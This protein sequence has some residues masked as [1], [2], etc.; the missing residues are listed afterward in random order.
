V[1]LFQ[2]IFETLVQFFANL[3]KQVAIFLQFK[4]HYKTVVKSHWD[5]Y[6][7]TFLAV[8]TQKTSATISI[9]PS[10]FVRF[11]MNAV[12]S[13]VSVGFSKFPLGKLQGCICADPTVIAFRKLTY[14]KKNLYFVVL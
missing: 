2:K 6:Q 11:E 5:E 14:N 4:V 1:R 12:F 13:I 9:V 8:C 7:I 3:E 10:L